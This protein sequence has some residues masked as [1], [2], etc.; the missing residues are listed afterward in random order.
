MRTEQGEQNAVAVGARIDRGMGSTPLCRQRP[1]TTGR[2]VAD[3]RDRG[4]TLSRLRVGAAPAGVVGTVGRRLRERTSFDPVT[5]TA[6][7]TWWDV[8]HP[9]ETITQTLRCYT[10]ADRRAQ[11]VSRFRNT[12]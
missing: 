3:P 9:E 5:C 4:R 11:A 6:A 1:D 10:P 2:L 7:D 8:A 12:Q